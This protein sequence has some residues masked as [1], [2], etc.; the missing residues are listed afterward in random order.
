MTSKSFDSK[1]EKLQTF[2]TINKLKQ[3]YLLSTLNNYYGFE[4]TW[5]KKTEG[6]SKRFE[7]HSEVFKVKLNSSLNRFKIIF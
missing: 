6:N 2:V 4:K 5:W 3:M 1:K 7:R